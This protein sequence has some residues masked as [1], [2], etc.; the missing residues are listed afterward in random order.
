MSPLVF[1]LSS[2]SLPEK[3]RGSLGDSGNGV[4][5][6]LK[7]FTDGLKNF[8]TREEQTQTSLFQTLQQPPSRYD[9]Y[10]Q[11]TEVWELMALVAWRL[12]YCS[13]IYIALYISKPVQFG[14][15]FTTSIHVQA[16]RLTYVYVINRHICK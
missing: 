16:L 12:F 13:D 8:I 14:S 10:E 2:L 3:A 11:N 4:Q 9:L 1:P 6:D 15:R 7:L 5:F